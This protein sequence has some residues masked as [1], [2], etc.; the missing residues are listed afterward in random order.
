MR[1]IPRFVTIMMA[2]LTSAESKKAHA[3]GLACCYSHNIHKFKP[4]PRT[5]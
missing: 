5:F 2:G 1:V 4:M 3:I